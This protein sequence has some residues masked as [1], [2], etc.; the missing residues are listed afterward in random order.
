[1]KKVFGVI[2]ARMGST[3][4][5]GKVMRKL[6][7]KSVFEHHVERMCNVKGLAGVYLATSTDP[8]NDSLIEESKRLG[9]KYFRGPEEDILARHI[10]ICGQENADAVIRVTC[11]MP[12][13]DVPSASRYVELFDLETYDYIYIKNMTPIQ[14]TVPE[15]I[16]SAALIRSHNEYR[17][18]AITQPIK[19]RLDEYKSLGL[20]LANDLVRPEYRLT[21]DVEEDFVVLGRIYDEL[22]RGVPISLTEV[23][24]FLDDYPEVAAMN[25]KVKI[26]G[27]EVMSSNLLETPLYSIVP[28]GDGYVIL[29]GNKS[30]VSFNDFIG[31]IE[32]L[33]R[34]VK[35]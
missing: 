26:K 3:R 20:D 1:M 8:Q 31:K 28:S 16:S 17:G 30:L 4:S 33:F 7:G 27:C 18:P 19:E 35:H 23:Y 2:T 10:S 34:A 11:D 9:I 12:L 21:I 29:D 24:K 22:Y 15:L 32:V 6:A 25:S 13:F 14:G 5:P